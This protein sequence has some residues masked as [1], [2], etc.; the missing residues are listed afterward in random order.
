MG[1]PAFWYAAAAAIGE[2]SGLVPVPEFGKLVSAIAARR[3][4]IEIVA[5]QGADEQAEKDQAI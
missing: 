3:T 4:I 1:F 5:R 2:I